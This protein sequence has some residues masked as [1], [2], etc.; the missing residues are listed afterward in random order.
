MSRAT[1]DTTLQ[2]LGQSRSEHP[3]SES[4]WSQRKT[5]VF[6]LLYCSAA[7]AALISLGYFLFF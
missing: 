2:D 4:K 3:S 7:W 6:I 5:L 1:F